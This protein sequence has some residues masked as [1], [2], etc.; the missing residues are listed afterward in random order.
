MDVIDIVFRLIGVFYAFGGLVAIR[1]AA[2][3][4]V[5]DRAISMITLKPRPRR[6]AVRAWLLGA[7]AVVTLA[8]GVALAALSQWAVP[9]FLIGTTLQIVWLFWARHAFPPEDA[10]DQLGRRQTTNAALGYAVV[11]LGVVW[12]ANAGR[13]APFDATGPAIAIGVAAIA[14]LAY[15][16]RSLGWWTGGAFGSRDDD[17]DDNFDD[18]EVASGDDG[19]RHP[20]RIRLV[21]S[22]Y[23]DPLVDA[24]DGRILD[25]FDYLPLDLAERIEAWRDAWVAALDPDTHEPVFANPEAEAASHADAGA[26]VSELEAI[27]GE[28]AVEA[29][30]FLARRESSPKLLP[31]A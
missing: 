29:P 7:G 6:E 27:Y 20:S 26:I 14:G 3:D 22:V 4:V 24:D 17:L 28:G 2:L 13:L 16:A 25:H 31:N 18:D 21:P 23:H 19:L 12:L 9:F 5:L 8:S 30:E 15:L 1:A 10:D 11:L